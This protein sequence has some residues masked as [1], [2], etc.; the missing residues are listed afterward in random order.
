MT[1]LSNTLDVIKQYAPDFKPRLGLILGSGLGGVADIIEDAIAIPY[2][3]IPG[4]AV[5]TVAGHA[6]R[7][8]LGFLQGIPVA[9]LQGRAHRYE[10]AHDAQIRT[11]VRTLKMLGCEELIITNAA[12]SLH[13]EVGEGS[14]M[15]ITDHIN[16]Q[17]STP[18]TGPNDEEFGPR[19]F[20]LDPAYDPQMCEGIRRAAKALD[21]ALTEG[22][23][24]AVLGPNY[25]TPAEIRAFRIL[26]ADAVGMSTVPEVI[27]ARHCGLRVAAISSITNMAAGLSKEAAN[28]EEVLHFGALAAKNL[29]RLIIAYVQEQAQKRG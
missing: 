7:L 8:L 28:H 11:M 21:I 25:E 1:E 26:G 29:T 20:P 16:F 10:G 6:G 24:L 23:Y 19:F 9:C 13:P 12:G 4:F 3:A 27:V 15:L 17:T 14:L 5:S 2:G 18:L 22:V